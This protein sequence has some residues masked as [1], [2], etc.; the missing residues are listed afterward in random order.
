MVNT[1][2]IVSGMVT[3]LEI[4]VMVQN[5][6]DDAFGVR[7]NVTYNSAIIFSRV[8]PENEVRYWIMFGIN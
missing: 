6:G 5:N 3:S 4:P 8:A 1:M 2:S 7:I